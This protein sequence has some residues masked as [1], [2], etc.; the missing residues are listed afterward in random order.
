MLRV[1]VDLLL[2]RVSTADVRRRAA[3]LP[4]RGQEVRFRVRGD[5]LVARRWASGA[6]ASGHSVLRARLAQ[7]P[8]GVRVRGAV[9]PSGL[10]LLLVA[11]WLAVAGGLATLGAVYQSGV[12]WCA[13]LLPLA[14]GAAFAAWLPGAARAGHDALLPTLSGLGETPDPDRLR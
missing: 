14:F 8:D 4:R 5:V 2:P 7:E 10:D 3:E 6:H 9:A 1:P 12:A 11:I 13:A